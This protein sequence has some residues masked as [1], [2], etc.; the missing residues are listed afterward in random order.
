MMDS[1]KTA[2]GMWL[3]TVLNHL[4]NFVL[5]AFWMATVLLVVHGLLQRRRKQPVRWRRHWLWLF[6]SGVA[7]LLAGLVMFQRDGK[8]LTYVA[9]ALVMG[10]VQACLARTK[11]A[12]ALPQEPVAQVLPPEN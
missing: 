3:F 4:V 5:P 12:P 11:K 1:D 2:I 7:V 8:M 6:G 9:L 10:L